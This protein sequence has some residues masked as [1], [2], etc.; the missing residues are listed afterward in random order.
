MLDAVSLQTAISTG[1]I[2]GKPF[3]V[4][5][6]DK[7]FLSSKNL[8]NVATEVYKDA[9]ANLR[10]EGDES[11]K[12]ATLSRLYRAYIVLQEAKDPDSPMQTQRSKIRAFISPTLR[13]HQSRIKEAEK[14]FAMHFQN[15]LEA[16]NGLHIE[17]P[18]DK[19]LIHHVDS[20]ELALGG[21]G[22][23][24]KEW[25]GLKEA[26]AIGNT[27]EAIYL[28]NNIVALVRDAS[29]PHLNLTTGTA[30]EEL[31][32]GTK[33]LSAFLKQDTN[34]VRNDVLKN[35][36][37][38]ENRANSNPKSQGLW[39]NVKAALIKNDN[40]A[41]EKNIYLYFSIPD[42]RIKQPAQQKEPLPQAFIVQETNINEPSPRNSLNAE[43]ESVASQNEFRSIPNYNA[44]E[45][46]FNEDLFSALQTAPS[47]KAL[48]R[49]LMQ[50]PDLKKLCERLQIPL[51]AD[52]LQAKA[53]AA[54]EVILTWLLNV[55]SR[56]FE[57][58]GIAESTKFVKAVISNPLLLEPLFQLLANG[59][60][61]FNGLSDTLTILEKNKSTKP[62]KPQ[63]FL[64]KIQDQYIPKA[65]VSSSRY[66]PPAPT[67]TV[68]TSKSDSASDLSDSSLFINDEYDSYEPSSA[69]FKSSSNELPLPDVTVNEKIQK[70][71]H[72]LSLLTNVKQRS[73]T[74][75]ANKDV[76]AKYQTDIDLKKMI[77][78]QNL[79]SLSEK[80]IRQIDPKILVQLQAI[81]PKLFSQLDKIFITI[82]PFHELF[83]LELDFVK[84]LSPDKRFIMMQRIKDDPL[85]KDTI[86]DFKRLFFSG[87]LVT[88]PP[89]FLSTLTK[90]DWAYTNELIYLNSPSKIQDLSF[91][92]DQLAKIPLQNLPDKYLFQL[93]KQLSE[94][95]PPPKELLG[96]MAEEIVRRKSDNLGTMTPEQLAAIP[97]DNLSLGTLLKLETVLSALPTP[98]Q[99][100]IAAVLHKIMDRTINQL[101]AMLP[102]A[103]YVLI[104][105]LLNIYTRTIEIDRST[106]PSLE[107]K[108]KESIKEFKS[109][110]NLDLKPNEEEVI[111]PLYSNLNTI[112]NSLYGK[113]PD[114]DFAPLTLLLRTLD[115]TAR[116]K[117]E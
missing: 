34:E 103:A 61:V 81:D 102:R 32:L 92:L 53:K 49:L 110:Q 70:D 23:A 11:S 56:F 65:D 26:L 17:T 45:V 105:R 75:K 78:F 117:A 68:S 79:L 13:Q 7:E 27:K 40:K 5:I 64:E 82:Y 58:N 85:G 108:L 109:F 98:P 77:I 2:D 83:K 41:L 73:I 18:L 74:Q 3:E 97:L 62:P 84:S 93:E 1:N 46:R 35:F 16:R 106:D 89:E 47:Y 29:P 15:Y 101:G 71:I 114:S 43:N 31:L 4:L 104:F 52:N 111:K 33:P 72:E 116:K 9:L 54:E 12:N 22:I 59:S 90:E 24:S 6:K 39:D 37:S 94:T 67:T 14:T 30:V 50:S 66:T 19:K 100:Q 42:E 20:I 8:Y 63:H 95:T 91:N 76:V 57:N 107:N 112:I 115:P 99:E 51:E 44:T 36:E 25:K 113:F 28:W 60:H 88:L 38:L 55:S 10:K 69:I 48:H 96:Q 87:I 86:V 80:E 21:L